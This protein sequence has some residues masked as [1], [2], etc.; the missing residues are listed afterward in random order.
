MSYKNMW[1]YL[2]GQYIGS[3]I[4]LPPSVKAFSSFLYLQ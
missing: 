4:V 2:Q 3:H 1:K